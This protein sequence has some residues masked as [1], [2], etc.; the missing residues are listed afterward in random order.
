[1]PFRIERGISGNPPAA[2]RRVLKHWQDLQTDRDGWGNDAPWWYNER[3]SLSQWVGAVWRAGGWAFEEYV[4]S[5]KVELED[6]RFVYASRNIS[7]PLGSAGR[8]RVDAA[9]EVQRFRAVLEAK[10]LWW[11]GGGDDSGSFREAVAGIM[12]EAH[13]QVLGY[14]NGAGRYQRFGLVFVVPH[15]PVSADARRIKGELRAL[16][17]EARTNRAWM[18][19]WAFPPETRELLSRKRRRYPGILL[20]AQPAE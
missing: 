3:A 15:F 5:K 8:G 9:M 6:G 16:L 10:Q 11:G 14:P 13:R 18:S 4:A 2:L 17:S 12:Q 1:M 19:A 7:A 20:V